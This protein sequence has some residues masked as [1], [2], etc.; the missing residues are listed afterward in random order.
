MAIKL[1]IDALKRDMED[2]TDSSNTFLYELYSG[3]LTYAGSGTDPEN[4]YICKCY[5]V[6]NNATVTL[7]FNIEGTYGA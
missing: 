6:K 3:V 7:Y 5:C 4:D 1:G 2:Q